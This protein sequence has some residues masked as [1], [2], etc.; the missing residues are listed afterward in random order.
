MNGIF[1]IS[2]LIILTGSFLI[3]R[4]MLRQ[5]KTGNK[6]TYGL[7]IG[8]ILVLLITDYF[9]MNIPL[10]SYFFVQQVSPWL[11]RVLGI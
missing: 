3:D 10:P 9:H 5:T 6:I 4:K 2:F 8:I 1:I 11:I 7:T